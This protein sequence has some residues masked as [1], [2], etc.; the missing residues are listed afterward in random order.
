MRD[1]DAES[2]DYRTDGTPTGAGRLRVPQ[3]RVCH[4]RVG[5]RGGQFD[6]SGG[7][8]RRLSHP[9]FH[10]Q[11]HATR[12][13]GTDRKTEGYRPIGG[14]RSPDEYRG[15]AD[16]CRETAR[17]VATEKEQSHLLAMAKIWDLT[18][19]RVETRPQ[20]RSIDHGHNRLAR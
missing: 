11:W 18:A 1:E 16:W 7:T 3:M 13:K 20:R 9:H 10:C 2:R 19:A 15:L 6:G 17:R 14:G 4:E 12:P 5:K 8:P